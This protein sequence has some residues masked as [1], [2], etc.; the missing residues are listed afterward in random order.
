MI[1]LA[2]TAVLCLA[3]AAAA[4]PGAEAF[5]SGGKL[6]AAGDAEGALA[7]M[8]EALQAEPDS[9]RFGS[10]YR[11]AAIQVEAYDRSIAF[12]E[13]LVDV[14]PS[15]NTHLN[16]G[17]AYVDKIP[18]AGAIT[19]IIL[20]NTALNHFAK[21][22]E[23]EE[24]WRTYFTRGASLLFWPKIFERA[25]LAVADLEEAMRLQGK[26][27]VRSYH[28][29]TYI[30]LGDGYWKTNQIEKARTTW[31]QG[32]DAFPDEERLGKRLALEG[33]PLAAYIEEAL[34]PNT[35]VDTDLREIWE[36]EESE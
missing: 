36:A 25:P 20:A 15:A 21:A 19:Q 6:L 29:R 14:H 3:A 27:P 32:L 26:D 17:F 34:D 23:S 30:S 31:Q 11:Q 1:G 16:H 18:A 10:E 33:N 2:L 13:K 8:E 5:E 7:A 24:A 22:I 35:R 9:L 28:V 12:F 4:G